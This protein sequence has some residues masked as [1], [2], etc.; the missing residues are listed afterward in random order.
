MEPCT[1]KFCCHPTEQW[2]WGVVNLPAGQRSEI[3]C[4][5]DCQLV[6]EEE[7]K[8]VGMA[9]RYYL[10]LFFI[11]YS[12]SILHLF[13]IAQLKELTVIFHYDYTLY[14]YMWQINLNLNLNFVAHNVLECY[15]FFSAVFLRVNTNVFSKFHVNSCFGNTVY[16]VIKML[17]CWILISPIVYCMLETFKAGSF[18]CLR[19]NDS[20]SD[21]Q[22]HITKVN[23]QARQINLPYI[24][25]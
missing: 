15:N 4:K 25:V 8:G 9:Q 24:S 1:G 21:M 6:P 17:T 2:G 3:Y 19:D 7:N 10:L 23:P 22:S 13:F 11:L 18:W 16:L 5:G 14:D 12:Y 20:H